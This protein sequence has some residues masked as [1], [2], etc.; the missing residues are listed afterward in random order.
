MDQIVSDQT[1]IDCSVADWAVLDWNWTV[2]ACIVVDQKIAD[3]MVTD[4]KTGTVYLIVDWTTV[5][6]WTLSGQWLIR[7]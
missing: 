1:G 3:W 6:D 5:L 4:Y 7:L 2:I